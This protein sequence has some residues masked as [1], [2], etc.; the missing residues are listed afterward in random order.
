MRKSIKIWTP[1]HVSL[2]NSVVRPSFKNL[3]DNFLAKDVKRMLTFKRWPLVAE[4][5]LKVS[6][7]CGPKFRENML[8]CIH[9]RQLD[10]PSFYLI[11]IFPIYVRFKHHR[12]GVVVGRGQTLSC[13]LIFPKVPPDPL[14]PPILYEYKI[15]NFPET[16]DHIP[17]KQ[18]ISKFGHFEF[19]LCQCKR[20]IYQSCHGHSWLSAFKFT[21]CSVEFQFGHFEFQLCL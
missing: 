20:Q 2:N 19:Q 3:S 16:L 5:K 1:L 12:Y 10:P 4:L 17:K 13:I 9:T 14:P 18:E 7:G 15:E 6:K 21:K 11:R 8:S